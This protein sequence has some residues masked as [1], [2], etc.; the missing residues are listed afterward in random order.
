MNRARSSW[1]LAGVI[2]I[3]IFILVSFVRVYFKDYELRNEIE[4]VRT[5][6]SSLEKRKIESLE[7]LKR[8]QSD[9]YVEERARVELQVVRPGEAML[10]VPG[11][12]VSSTA[13]KS[14]TPSSSVRPL[15][16]PQKWWYYFFRPRMGN[17]P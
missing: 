13:S 17:L 3:C 10:I 1:A 7:V 6:V 14:Y 8:L 2:I 15:S 12:I 4:R 9:A 16:N 5:Q 11:Q